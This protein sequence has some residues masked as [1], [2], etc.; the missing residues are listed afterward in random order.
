M[1]LATK[2]GRKFTLC[3]LA[4]IVATA[5]M[6]LRF[7]AFADWSGFMLGDLGIYAGANVVQ[8]V[9][10]RIVLARKK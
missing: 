2:D 4:G 8:K 5:A 3:L 9:G 6:F 1:T 10:A 7:C